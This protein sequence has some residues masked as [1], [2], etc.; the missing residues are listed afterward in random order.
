MFYY[1]HVKDSF[2]PLRTE[3]IVSRDKHHKSPVLTIISDHLGLNVINHENGKEYLFNNALIHTI[4]QT[5]SS[6]CLP[7]VVNTCLQMVS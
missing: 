7:H 6:A 2:S 1:K 5:G 3:T 4:L